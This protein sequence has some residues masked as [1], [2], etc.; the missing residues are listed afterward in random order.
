MTVQTRSMGS[1]HSARAMTT[2]WLTP[3]HI[4]EALGP[5][6]LDP[7]AYPDWPTA[8]TR[9]VLPTDGLAAEWKGRVWLNPPYS[10]GTYVSEMEAVA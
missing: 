4:I 7:C 5:F 2:T 6:D 3:L 8:R 1:H 9:L 10:S